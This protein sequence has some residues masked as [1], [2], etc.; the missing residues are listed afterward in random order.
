MLNAY[1][2]KHLK[3]PDERTKFE[4]AVRA[5]TYVLSRLDAIIDEMTNEIER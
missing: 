5:D 4:E 2:T 1:W 3:T